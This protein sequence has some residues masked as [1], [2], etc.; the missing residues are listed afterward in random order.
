MQISQK[1]LFLAAASHFIGISLQMQIS[2]KLLK[3]SANVTYVTGNKIA[4][5]D[6]FSKLGAFVNNV[7]A[8][9]LPNFTF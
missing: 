1:R 9:I 7:R 5:K 3:K 4:N 8:I 6:M 2:T